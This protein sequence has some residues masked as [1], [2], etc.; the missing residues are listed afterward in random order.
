MGGG[1]GELREVL[2]SAGVVDP[3]WHEVKKTRRVESRVAAAIEEGAGVVFV[4]GGDGSVRAALGPLVGKHAALAI[5]PAG[6]ANLLA[7]N[8]GVPRDLHAAVAVGLRGRRRRL[9][10]GRLNGEYFAVMGGAGFDALLIRDA[11][12]RLKRRLGRLA[13]VWTGARHLNAPVA[14]AVVEIDGRGWFRGSASCV[15]V[16]NVG[17]ITGGIRAFPDADTEDGQLE[18]GVVTARGAW[19]WTRAFASLAAGRSARSPL[20]RTT[21]GRTVDVTLDRPQAYELDG[22][23]RGPT[24][25]LRAEAVPQAVTVCVP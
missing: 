13:Y 20:I 3:I 5:L 7:V 11:H 22:D 16:G 23:Y 19:Q 2:H 15:M 21:R 24:T 9:D 8:L 10:V 18:V 6:T 1:L 25:T 14:G 12:R 17:R 4:W